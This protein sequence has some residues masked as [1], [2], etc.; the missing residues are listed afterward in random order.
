MERARVEVEV[1]YGVS[2]LQRSERGWPIVDISQLGE[3]TG[4][5]LKVR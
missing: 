5:S 3:R 2:R 4:V 1:R